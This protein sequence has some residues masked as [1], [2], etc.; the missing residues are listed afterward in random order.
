MFDR[1]V[2]IGRISNVKDS[3]CRATSEKTK[4]KPNGTHI[5]PPT[6]YPTHHGYTSLK[7]T[8]TH[9]SRNRKRAKNSKEESLLQGMSEKICYYELLGI[10]RTASETEIKKAYRKLAVKWHPDKNP[11]DP[12]VS[13]VCC[14]CSL[15]ETN[16]EPLRCLN[17]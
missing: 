11:D 16:R 12:E 4:T 15:N 14:C 6:H 5:S 10:E 8:S 7:P 13:L 9:F 3:N 17:L 1:L 2:V